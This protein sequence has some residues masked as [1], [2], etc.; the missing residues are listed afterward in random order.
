MTRAAF[1]SE[2]MCKFVDSVDSVY[3]E[4]DITAAL[5]PTLTPM[6]ANGR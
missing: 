3:A 6:F 4:A 2:Y 1:E 5:D